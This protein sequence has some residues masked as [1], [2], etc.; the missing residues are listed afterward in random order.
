MW[1]EG[2]RLP[3]DPKNQAQGRAYTS[4]V[5][6]IFVWGERQLGFSYDSALLRNVHFSHQF[7]VLLK[8]SVHLGRQRFTT[9][10]VLFL[11]GSET[12]NDAV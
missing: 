7:S 10:I 6:W 11:D 1:K 5:S 3:W 8:L 4:P 2:P 9:G 12:I